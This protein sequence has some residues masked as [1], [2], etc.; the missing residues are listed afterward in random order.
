MP[1]TTKPADALSWRRWWRLSR[2]YFQCGRTRGLANG[3]DNKR[4]GSGWTTK[5]A[6]GRDHAQVGVGECLVRTGVDGSAATLNLTD[7]EAPQKPPE[8]P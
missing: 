2:A 3:F 5:R 1:A 8:G 6:A 7:A 4:C